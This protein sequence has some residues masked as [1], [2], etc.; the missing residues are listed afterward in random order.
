[1]ASA[2]VSTLRDEKTSSIFAG[3]E[4][5]E[6]QYTSKVLCLS[7]SCCEA[8]SL[9]ITSTIVTDPGLNCGPWKTRLVT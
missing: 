2:E 9:V 4:E 5:T 3:S 7:L 6:A 8:S 1:M